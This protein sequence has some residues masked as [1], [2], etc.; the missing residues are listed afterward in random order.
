MGGLL[1]ICP[2]HPRPRH[3]PHHCWR[4]GLQEE[5]GRQWHVAFEGISKEIKLNLFF[6]DWSISAKLVSHYFNSEKNALKILLDFYYYFLNDCLKLCKGITDILLS[7]N[8]NS[9][10]NFEYK[11]GTKFSLINVENSNNKLED[12]FYFGFYQ[13]ILNVLFYPCIRPSDNIVY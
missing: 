12:T 4:R 9:E 1:R 11:T 2:W 13:K 10:C 8:I 5:P 7:I 3:H 6:V